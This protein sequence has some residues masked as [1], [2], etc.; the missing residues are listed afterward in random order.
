M[1]IINVSTLNELYAAV[2]NST[3]AG[4][5]IILATGTYALLSQDPNDG[6]RY[7]NDGRIE[8]QHD[9][10]IRGQ[11]GNSTLVTIDESSLPVTSFAIPP[12]R[13]GGIRMGNGNNSLEWLTIVGK[14]DPLALS[15][16]D[17][18]LPSL[19]THIKIANLIIKGSQTGIDVRN[20]NPASAGRII[21]AEITENEL[22]GNTVGGGQGITIQNSNGATGSII[23]V[24]M[25][26]NKIKGNKIGCRI[27]NFA[28]KD[29]VVTS[30]ASINV[31]STSDHFDENGIGI[32]LNGGAS[33]GQNAIA[34]N[35]SISFETQM[36]SIM[37]NGHDTALFI[38]DL[39]QGGIYAVAGFSSNVV[40]TKATSN[41][42]LKI[43]L[44]SSQFSGN[45][46]SDI[47]S[48]ATVSKTVPAGTNN[49][50]ELEF[51]GVISS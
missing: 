2:N 1:S 40:G 30:L 11:Q 4:N 33:T 44:H 27:W 5:T 37:N 12:N 48:L 15:A 32:L 34:D 23:N 6:T 7:P 35:N 24:Q 21:D 38:K 50:L 41:N 51:H 25:A 16:I 31:R 19:K 8:F 49:V 45:D 22:T 10:K 36:A 13:T 3:N 39:P 29:N 14:N 26:K 9:M 43:N 42:R 18:D 20:L 47:F 17:T 46:K 28:G